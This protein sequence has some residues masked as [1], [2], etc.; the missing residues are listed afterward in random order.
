MPSFR[1]EKKKKLFEVNKSRTSYQAPPPL[2]SWQ[3]AGLYEIESFSGNKQK[4]FFL[5]ERIEQTVSKFFKEEKFPRN[6]NKFRLG[7]N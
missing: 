7:M 6:L 4:I 2:A 1:K 5:V 3:K